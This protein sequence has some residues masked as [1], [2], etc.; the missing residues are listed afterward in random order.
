MWPSLV[1]IQYIELKLLCGNDPVG[2]NSIYSNDDLDLW[3]NDSKINRILPL[4]QGNHVAKFGED[5]IYR[6]IKLSCGNLCGHPPPAIPNHIIRPVSQDGRIKKDGIIKKIFMKINMWAERL[7]NDL[8]RG[9]GGWRWGY[10][11]PQAPVILEPQKHHSHPSN[12]HTIT[13]CCFLYWNEDIS[14]RSVKATPPPTFTCT[15]AFFPT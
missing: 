6:T 11:T 2:K 7:N 1:K 12:G 5:P 10:S 8:G 15:S 13:L 14:E 4:S 3:P 9:G